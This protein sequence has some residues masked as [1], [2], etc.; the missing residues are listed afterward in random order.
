MTQRQTPH[1]QTQ[2]FLPCSLHIR[3]DNPGE[4][5]QNLL[6]LP[7]LSSVV[8]SFMREGDSFTCLFG[9]GEACCHDHCTVKSLHTAK[10]HLHL[11]GCELTQGMLLLTAFVPS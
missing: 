7:A 9:A 8:L 1:C 5:G 11:M 10:A 6:I 2:P 3:R 4:L